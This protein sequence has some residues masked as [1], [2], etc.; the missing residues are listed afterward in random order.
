[1]PDNQAITLVD[2]AST[3]VNHVYSPRTVD[4]LM[5]VYQNL[6]QS[7]PSGRETLTLRK[8]ANGTVRTVYLDLKL[9]RVS[10]ETVG[11]QTVKSVLD[12]AT[13]KA[14][15]I[16]PVGWVDSQ[17]QIVRYLLAQALLDA[18][19]VTEVMDDDDWVY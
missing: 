5:A 13:A 14:E 17:T 6:G 2:N 18:D 9:P 4:G 12:F 11:D 1:M 8:K 7:L 16:V 19:I 15:I 10:E 3:P